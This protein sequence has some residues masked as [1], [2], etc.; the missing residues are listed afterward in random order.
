MQEGGRK[1]A[2]RA[3]RRPVDGEKS[4][5]DAEDWKVRWRPVIGCGRPLK[6]NV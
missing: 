6:V 2:G 5:E 4:E 1:P 3:E